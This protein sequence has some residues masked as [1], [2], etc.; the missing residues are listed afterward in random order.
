METNTNNSYSDEIEIDLGEVLMLMWHYAW[1]IGLCA[2]VA[3]VIGFCISKFAITPMYESTT[4]MYI[5]NTKETGNA[6]LTYSDLQ[7]G[8]QLTKDYAEMIRSRSVLEV[9]IENLQ[10]EEET[11]DS[12]ASRVTV[13]TPTDTRILSIKVL[14]PSPLWAQTIADEIRNVASTQIINVMDI[15]AVNVFEYADLPTSPA[16]PSVKKWAAIGFVIGAFLCVAVI[17]IRFLLDDTVKTS[18][19]VE[20]FLAMSTLA[21]IPLM[22]EQ[23]AQ[24]EKVRQE[25]IVRSSA[26]AGVTQ[27][28]EPEDEGGEDDFEAVTSRESIKPEHSRKRRRSR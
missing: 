23:E 11:Y 9:V 3:A 18:E 14:D 8:S 17:L 7:L 20:K 2:V 1:L 21:M 27:A 19:D 16:S 4:K 22:D 5:L 10:L 15:E 24:K 6:S 12:L 13:N 28:P 26:E 25:R